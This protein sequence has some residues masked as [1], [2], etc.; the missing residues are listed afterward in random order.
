M[1]DASDVG[2]EVRWCYKL[3]T[4]HLT[5]VASCLLSQVIPFA[6][7]KQV[8]SVMVYCWAVRTRVGYFS[9]M[10]IIYMSFKAM[11]DN[12]CITLW[13]RDPFVS[14]Q[15]TSVHRCSYLLV[16]H[17]ALSSLSSAPPDGAPFLTLSLLQ[18]YLAMVQVSLEITTHLLATLETFKKFKVEV[19]FLKVIPEADNILENEGTSRALLA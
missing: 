4:A 10:T 12:K 15:M 9:C 1:V 7:T 16:T 18:M 14:S 2:A 11:R 5:Q 8:G 3:L 17:T 19:S 6:V 13:A